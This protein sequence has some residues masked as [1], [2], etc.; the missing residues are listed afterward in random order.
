MNFTKI[1]INNYNHL[2]YI[3]LKEDNK[4]YNGRNYAYT[5]LN[6][7]K[8]KEYIKTNYAILTKYIDNI[9]IYVYKKFIAKEVYNYKAINL[10]PLNKY[11]SFLFHIP[12]ELKEVL[13]QETNFNIYYIKEGD[14]DLPNKKGYVYCIILEKK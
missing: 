6:K 4:K 13:E 3:D 12:E 1:D 9:D 14:I 10:K 11:T 8:I 2:D 5:L 7:D